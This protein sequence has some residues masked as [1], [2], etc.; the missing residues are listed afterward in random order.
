MGVGART[1]VDAPEL[2]DAVEADDLLEELVPVLLST[3][4][5][6]EPES[7]GMLQRVLDVEI[8]RVV[9]DGH[10]LVTVGRLVAI[11]PVGLVGDASLWRDWDGIERHWLRWV[12]VGGDF[13]HGC[14]Y[15]RRR[16]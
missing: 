4:W 11:D 9:E 7:P 12:S 16:R 3:R 10:D 2:L 14:G 8:L 15:E 1:H 5:L 13:G 6:G